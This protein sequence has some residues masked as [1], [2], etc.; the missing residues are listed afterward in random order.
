MKQSWSTKKY[1]Y[2]D[3][4]INFVSWLSK[5]HRKFATETEKWC[6]YSPAHFLWEETGGLTD[7]NLANRLYHEKEIEC[8]VQSRITLVVHFEFQAEFE[9]S[10]QGFGFSGKQASSVYVMTGS[11]MYTSHRT[12]VSRLHFSLTKGLLIEQH[13]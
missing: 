2:T 8:T 6:L 13:S 4:T 11:F 7:E 1:T 5:L 10:V 3:N 9:I 12:I